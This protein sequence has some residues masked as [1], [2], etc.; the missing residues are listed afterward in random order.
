MLF[1]SYPI[2]HSIICKELW[3]F[4]G[5]FMNMS[6]EWQLNAQFKCLCFI[7]VGWKSWR[8]FGAI[9]LCGFQVCSQIVSW[10]QGIL[11]QELNLLWKAKIKMHHIKFGIFHDW[12]FMWILRFY[13]FILIRYQQISI[14][15]LSWLILLNYVV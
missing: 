9:L 5:H 15:Y 12:N 7:N 8:S 2:K 4:C 11:R 3:T 10:N 13:N 1:D 14:F 6:I